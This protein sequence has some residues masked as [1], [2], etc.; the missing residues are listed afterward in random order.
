MA[1]TKY[2]TDYEKA[3]QALGDR[4]PI[5]DIASLN[6]SLHRRYEK[7]KALKVEV[8]A[9]REALGGIMENVRY[10]QDEDG[11]WHS[12]YMDKPRAAEAT[13]RARTLLAPE[14]SKVNDDRT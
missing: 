7:E 1:T 5:A 11:N 2:E 4:D 14:L 12:I 6:R 13:E 3:K 9:F 10:E 8:R